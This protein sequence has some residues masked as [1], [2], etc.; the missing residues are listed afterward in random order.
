MY[1]VINFSPVTRPNYP[2]LVGS[3]GEYKEVL[4][5]DEFRFGGTGIINEKTLKSK[6]CSTDQNYIEINLPAL[7]GIIIRKIRG[8]AR[9]G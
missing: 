4:N 9:R 3:A 7:S 6:I 8:R 2:I 1:V 5:T